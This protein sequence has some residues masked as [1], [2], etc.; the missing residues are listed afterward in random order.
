[1]VEKAVIVDVELG[2][3]LADSRCRLLARV[4]FPLLWVVETTLVRQH[5]R[6]L[7]MCPQVCGSQSLAAVCHLRV[8]SYLCPLRKV[9]IMRP[10]PDV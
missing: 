4:G 3:I 2:A 5:F 9:A 8:E 10:L 7:L 6:C 1:M